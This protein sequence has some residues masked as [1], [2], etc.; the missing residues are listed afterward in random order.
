MNAIQGRDR[1]N[2]PTNNSLVMY[3]LVVIRD[4][5]ICYR[6]SC[7]KTCFNK[8]AQN[9]LKVPLQVFK[10]AA[11]GWGIRPIYDIPEGTFICI[12]AGQV[13]TEQGANEVCSLLIKYD[14]LSQAGL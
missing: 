14:E 13:L 2:Y 5:P 9:G 4:I 1:I 7:R 8:V 10:T 6:C 3:R 11:K 12:Y